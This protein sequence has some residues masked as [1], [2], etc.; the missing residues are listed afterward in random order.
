MKDLNLGKGVFEIFCKIA[1]SPP[2]Q[3]DMRQW[4]SRTG[5]GRNFP[6]SCL[7]A[8]ALARRACLAW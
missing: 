4:I 8:A 3:G 5:K 1:V 6:L 2:N 7:L